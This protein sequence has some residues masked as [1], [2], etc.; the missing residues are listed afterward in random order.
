MLP[1]ST[2]KSSVTTALIE[3]NRVDGGATVAVPESAMREYWQL[4][5]KFS[6]VKVETLLEGHSYIVMAVN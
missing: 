2:T 4:R 1:E 3:L 5:M 6:Y